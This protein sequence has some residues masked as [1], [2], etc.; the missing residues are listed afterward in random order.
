VGSSVAA[1]TFNRGL[2][3]QSPERISLWWLRRHRTEEDR[4]RLYYYPYSWPMGVDGDEIDYGSLP[5]VMRSNQVDGLWVHDPE[6][7][8]LLAARRLWAQKAIPLLACLHAVNDAWVVSETIFTQLHGGL[9]PFDALVSPSRCGALAYREL[10]VVC[11]E[12]L[13]GTGAPVVPQPTIAVI[14]YGIDRAPLTGLDRHECRRAVN[15]P[16]DRLILL[17][18]GRLNQHDKGDLLPLLLVVERLRHEFSDLL[19][20]VAGSGT[21]YAE[22]LHHTITALDLQRH[23]TLV[24]EVPPADKAAYFGAADLFVGLSDTQSETHGLTILEAMA[25]G[26][27]VVAAH[28]DGYAELIRHGT[29]GFLIPTIQSSAPATF[30]RL[31][32]VA[33]GL[34]GIGHGDLNESVA[35]DVGELY[36][37][38]RALCAN[39]ALRRQLGAAGAEVCGR[40]YDHVRQTERMVDALLTSV[41][42]CADSPWPP[43]GTKAPFYDAVGDRFAHYA[44]RSLDNSSFVVLGWQGPEPPLNLLP[45]GDVEAEVELARRILATVIAGQPVTLASLTAK[46]R[47]QGSHYNEAQLRMRV[48]RC[49]KYGL[50]AIEDRMAIEFSDADQARRTSDGGD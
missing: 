48:A 19:L 13:A 37:G 44:S 42:A 5:A 16:D 35:F 45:F 18:L 34:A 21:P 7:T 24:P 12:W 1:D 14:P 20:V 3:A 10:W 41:R 31:Q 38:L 8:G 50:L 40:D 30:A 15:L 36:Q 27:P 25:A 4:Q 43:P 39:P 28:W 26:L 11:A 29:T 6:I 22:T 32:R 46:L 23:V 17:S 33:E 2:M 47:E 49:L 9:Q